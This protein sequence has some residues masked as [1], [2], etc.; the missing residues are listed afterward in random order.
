MGM[1]REDVFEGGFW[2]NKDE[3]KAELK[4]LDMIEGK[5]FTDGTIEGR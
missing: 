2:K 4:V 1:G 3:K 5:A